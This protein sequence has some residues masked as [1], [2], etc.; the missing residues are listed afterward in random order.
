MLLGLVVH[1]GK[2][3]LQVVVITLVASFNLV[4]QISSMTK[5]T[6]T[7]SLQIQWPHLGVS[8]MLT[9]I[10]MVLQTIWQTTFIKFMGFLPSLLLL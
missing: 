10:Q 6:K 1:K 4:K 3:A 7:S 2:I 8:S 9:F 5:F